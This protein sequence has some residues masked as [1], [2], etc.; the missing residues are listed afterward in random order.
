MGRWTK[1]E[2]FRFL[3]ALKLYG[4]EWKNVQAHVKTRTSTQ[5]RSHAQKFF[6]KLEKRNQSLVVFLETLD[7][8]DMEKHYIMSDLDDE[9]SLSV[10]SSPKPIIIESVLDELVESHEVKKFEKTTVSNTLAQKGPKLINDPEKSRQNIEFL[11]KKEKD[12]EPI[13]QQSSQT[14]RSKRQRKSNINYAILDKSGMLMDDKLISPQKTNDQKE[15]IKDDFAVLTES[16]QKTMLKKRNFNQVSKQSETF[17]Q[18]LPKTQGDGLARSIS[19]MKVNFTQQK[20]AESVPLFDCKDQKMN[21]RLEQQTQNH[22]YNQ[23]FLHGLSNLA[24]QDQSSGE[25]FVSILSKMPHHNS[26]HIPRNF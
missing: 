7:L 15:L 3:E 9:K 21:P 11:V 4:K 1:D 13:S 22:T 10:N 20:N 23:S 8:N 19:Q 6:N 5:A 12:L 16:A 26:F 18:P 14:S 2:H 25:Q 17:I 24:A